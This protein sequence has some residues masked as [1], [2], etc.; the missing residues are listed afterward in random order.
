MRSLFLACFLLLFAPFAWSCEEI[1]TFTNK[2]C[3]EDRALLEKFFRVMVESI[4]GFVIYGDKPIAV[5]PCLNTLVYLPYMNAGVMAFTKGK[6]LWQSLNIS[7]YDKEYLFVIF[8]NNG[9]TQFVAINRKAFIKV[10]NENISLFKYVLGPALT[11]EKL[12]QELIDAKNDFYNVLKNDNALLGILLGYGTQNA[13][14]GSRLELICCDNVDDQVEEFPLLPY[15]VRAKG[16]GEEKSQKKDP[17]IG[18]HTI[19][20]EIE[21]L[22]RGMKGS[23]DNPPLRPYELPFFG[24]EP[25]SEETK[26]L[27]FIY[28]K[29]QDDLLKAIK[30]P[31]FFERT[32]S[33][34]LTTTSGIVEIPP[35]PSKISCSFADSRETASEKLADLI[36][37]N[38]W[39]VEEHCPEFCLKSSLEGMESQENQGAEPIERKERTFPPYVREVC[40]LNRAL[41]YSKK[42][43]NTNDYFS[44]I[45]QDK[46]YISLI[47]NGIYYR[48]LRKG[49]GEPT[50]S[51][52]ETVSFHY[53]YR[54]L[55]DKKDYSRGTVK[56]ENPKHFIPGM[57]HALIGMQR[58]EERLVF[59]HPEYGYGQDFFFPPN[60]A[61]K[62]K[63]Q[64]LDFKEGDQDVAISAPTKIEM[65][66]IEEMQ[67]RLKELKSQEYHEM[68]NTLWHAIKKTGDFI[69]F[70]ILKKSI[71]KTLLAETDSLFSSLEEARNYSI[72]LQYFLL[73]RKNKMEATQKEAL[74]CL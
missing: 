19:D 50:S 72:E 39:Y 5:T 21:M 2:L 33:K 60:S 6:D 8:D 46:N 25:D 10:V 13:L 36:A 68:G 20:E 12:L 30:E 69:D 41:T 24:C 71:E 28:K 56:E 1:K 59:I 65:K 34:F 61:I 48:V 62:V 3:H 38:F 53:S 40:D 4:N 35:V 74:L 9:Y 29:N 73:S 44:R 37:I 52:I 63:V 7:P 18:F 23:H 55:G 26:N 51:K 47:P 67:E 27:F 22:N 14:I 43:K 57:I 70:Q 54:I 16:T 49:K 66:N 11:A 15:Q 32:L 17:S 58:G 31:D 64:L 42:L 45:I